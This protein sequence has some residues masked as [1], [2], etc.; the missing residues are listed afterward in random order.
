V[1][2]I[3]LIEN[4]MVKSLNKKAARLGIKSEPVKVDRDRLLQN[5]GKA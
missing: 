1:T 4:M 5:T 2:E 3:A